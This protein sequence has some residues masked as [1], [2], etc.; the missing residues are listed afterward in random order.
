MKLLF[1]SY[2]ASLRERG[3]L[4]AILP[5]LLSELGYHVY[6]RPQRG[7]AQAGVDIA[8]VGLDDDGK[9]KVFLFSVKQGDLTRQSWNDG[10]A[11]ALRPS[12]D[13]ILDNYIPNRIPKRYQKLKI[14]ICLVFG[15]DMQEQVRGTVN[16][17]TRRNSTK[18][19]SFD[20]WNGDKLAGL[21]LQGVLREEIMPKALRSHFQKSVSLVDEPDIAYRHFSRLVRELIGLANND[22]AKIRTARQLYIAT[23]VL[24]VWARDIGN[25]EAAYQASELLLL[26]LWDLVRPLI[27]KKRSAAG[28]AITLVLHYA[29]RMHLAIAS[30]LVE[31]KILPHVGI[32][33]GIA[34]AIQGRS[35]A[36]INLKLFDTLGRIA[37]T[38]LWVH[39]L[40]E[41]YT[42][43]SARVEARLKIAQFTELGFKLIN[44]NR[45]LFL[46]LQDQ[47]GIEVAM[48]LLFVTAVNG[49]RH[50]AHA[51]LREMVN[52]L[53]YS[54]RTHGKYPCVFLEYRALVAH[55]RERTEEYRKEATAGSILIPI[56]EVFLSALESKESLEKLVDLKTKELAHC[57]LQVWLPDI[58]SEDNLYKGVHDH[59]V[60]LT[61]VPLSLTGNELVS[62]VKNACDETEGY[63]SLSAIVTG[64]W[65]IIMTACRHHRMPI[66]PQMWIDIVYDPSIEAAHKG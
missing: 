8:A 17:Y 34:M 53:S 56:L 10:S 12:L 52:R 48:F 46:P 25:V 29:I 64:Y 40:V 23:W 66:P 3:E 41:R 65:P 27:G 24:F 13:E 63:A 37:L 60:S 45:A 33:D 43:E 19:V 38:G 36:D 35:S 20:E 16:G 26:N 11:Q 55:P 39:W 4:D 57:T 58:S 18:K 6:S 14:V 21:L 1:R 2:L 32:K 22:K 47:H 61:D 50:D 44:N 5:D 7:T 28:K 9:K 59:G 15:G 42:D 51:W 31:R 62:L 54:I 49:N 30:E